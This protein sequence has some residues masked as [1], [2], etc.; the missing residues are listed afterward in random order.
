MAIS[1]FKSKGDNSGSKGDKQIKKPNKVS[2]KPNTISKPKPKPKNKTS[3]HEGNI[4][5]PRPRQ[6]VQAESVNKR[7]IEVPSNAPV[8]NRGGNKV[9]KFNYTEPITIKKRTEPIKEVEVETVSDERLITKR[10]ILETVN[11]LSEIT[12]FQKIS[13]VNYFKQKESGK[14]DERLAREEYRRN[15]EALKKETSLLYFLRESAKRNLEHNEGK[16]YRKIDI[17]IDPKYSLED[18]RRFS[19]SKLL[20]SYNIEI[21]HNNDLLSKMGV[22]PI[23]VRMSLKKI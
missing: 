15:S 20:A 21:I 1:F 13:L 23:K 19:E 11:D 8:S 6:D 2:K 7:Q 18:I 5:R 10:P 3:T 17:Q 12:F 16:G 9:R 14:I 22:D 4:P